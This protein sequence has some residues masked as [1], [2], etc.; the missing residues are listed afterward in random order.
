MG[1]VGAMGKV[2]QLAFGTLIP[3]NPVPNL[4]AANV[5]GG[6]ASQCADLM[7][8]L[9]CGHLLGASPRLQT[10]AQVCGAVTGALV[11][12]AAYVLLI[13]DPA[14]ML[15]TEEWV[16]PAAAIWKSVA[17]LFMHGFEALPAGTPMAMAIAAAAGLVLPILASALPRGVRPLI[18]SPVGLGL[19]FVFPAYVVF[20]DLP[21]RFGCAAVAWLLQRLGRA[22]HR[23]DMRRP[24]RRREHDRHGD[25]AGGASARSRGAHDRGSWIMNSYQIPRQ[26][27]RVETRAGNS[28]FVT[29]ITPADSVKAAQAFVREMREEIA[30]RHA[31]RLRFQDR[32][33]RER[34]GGDERRWRALGHGRAAGIGRPSRGGDRRRGAG[35]HTLLRRNEARH[36]RPSDGLHQRRQGRSCRG[37]RP[38][39]R[40][41]A[42]RWSSPSR[43]H[44][45]SRSSGCWR[46]ASA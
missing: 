19:G 6:A 28:R 41:N 38:R 37:P 15:L 40:S 24:G 7:D 43:I 42:C 20:H 4:M 26:R 35:H 9:K 17:E 23:R 14:K 29:T 13:P 39:R 27:C 46:R 5:A 11:G 21:W 45:W 8:D 2:S 25:Q 44:C 1:A 10:L 33:R 22:L 12:S 18:L 31:P 30:G 3:R 36:R 32:P 34:V 16:A